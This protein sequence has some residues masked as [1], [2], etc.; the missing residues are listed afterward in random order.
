MSKKSYSV[1]EFKAKS[2]G[3]LEEVARDRSTITVTKRGVPIA[4]VIPIPAPSKTPEPGKLLDAL[5]FEEDIVS[6]LGARIWKAAE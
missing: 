4:K 6:P 2:L 3:L 1:S 5:L